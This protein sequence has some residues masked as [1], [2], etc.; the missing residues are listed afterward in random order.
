MHSLVLVDR[1]KYFGSNSDIWTLVIPL[2]QIIVCDCGLEHLSFS[3]KRQ[4]PKCAASW[5]YPFAKCTWILVITRQEYNSLC[6]CSTEVG[7]LSSPKVTDSCFGS[8]FSLTVVASLLEMPRNWLFAYQNVF[9]SIINIDTRIV[10]PLPKD[11]SFP[12][13]QMGHHSKRTS[14]SVGPSFT[15]YCSLFRFLQH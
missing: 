15:S 2:N 13:R 8:L 10:I 9:R 7:H 5:N 6:L 12:T 1:K 3:W 4:E 14:V 11:K